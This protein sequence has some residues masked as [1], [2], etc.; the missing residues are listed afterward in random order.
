[1]YVFLL[2]LW[3][4]GAVQGKHIRLPLT[5]RSSNNS[6]ST[7]HELHTQQRGRRLI[8]G[9]TLL[10]GSLHLGYYYANI[11]LGT[12]PQKADVILDTGSSVTAIPCTGCTDCG[13][14]SC[15]LPI[16]GQVAHPILLPLRRT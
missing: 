8:Q 14:R 12:P 13:P 2:C 6:R 3:M 9:D 1:M 15:S 11:W 7:M 16:V 4:P 10:Y 5:Y